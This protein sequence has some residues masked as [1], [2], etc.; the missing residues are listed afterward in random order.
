MLVWANGINRAI[1]FGGL[2]ANDNWFSFYE[3]KG[4]FF[5]QRILNNVDRWPGSNRAVLFGGL[6]A[7]DNV[8]SL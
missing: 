2:V 1:I 4:E 7:N 5:Q 6:V 8:N 3:G